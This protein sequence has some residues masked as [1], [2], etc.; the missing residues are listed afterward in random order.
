MLWRIEEG[1]PFLPEL[2]GC[3]DFPEH[4][5]TTVSKLVEPSSPLTSACVVSV[6]NFDF[7]VAWTC[8]SATEIEGAT[9]DA[10]PCPLLGCLLLLTWIAKYVLLIQVKKK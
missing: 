8:G 6:T 4:R 5:H 7:D 3:K 1:K 2:R 10:T 9:F